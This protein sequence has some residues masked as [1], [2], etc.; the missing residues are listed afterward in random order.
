MARAILHFMWGF[1]SHFRSSVQTQTRSALQAIGAGLG[2]TVTLVGF[3]ASDA[4]PFD[5]CVEPENQPIGGLDLAGIDA[6]AQQLYEADE[7][8]GA[9]YSNQALNEA[10][11]RALRARARGQ[12]LVEVMENFA[13]VPGR[14]YFTSSSARVGDYMVYTVVGVLASRWA[15][16]PTLT[17]RRRDR[18]T[19]QP[20]LADAVVQHVLRAATRALDRQQ[21]PDGISDETPGDSADLV[22]AA[23]NEFV[24]SIAVLAGDYFDTGLAQDLNAVAAQPYEGRTSVGSIVLAAR[25][26]DAAAASVS[27]DA[28]FRVAVPTRNPRAF[29]KVLEMS[30]PDVHLL[31]TGSE[32]YGLGRA[33]DNYDPS[34]ERVFTVSI[35]GRGTWELHHAG[36]PLLRIENTH[37][38][39]PRAPMSR[40]QFDDTVERLFPETGTEDI[41]RLWELAQL[42]A[43]QEHGTMLVVHRAAADEADRLA[44]QA[45]RIEPTLLRGDVLR[46]T[47]NIDGAVLVAPDGR[48][49]AV[50]V[51]LDGTATGDGDSARGARYNSAVRYLQAA[52][53][54]CLIIIVSE[55]GMINLLPNLRRRVRP[56]TV[57]SAVK[58]MEDA[59][60]GSPIDYETFFRRREHVETL[61]FYLDEDQC[62][63]LNESQERVEDARWQESAMRVGHSIFAPDPDMNDSYFL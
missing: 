39:L 27:I 55:D 43:A 3:R 16:L 20:S 45:L 8:Y 10:R 30:G 18:M 4:A 46:S 2:P 28:G 61:A 57:E 35:V 33:A 59:S 48:C 49:H 12:A 1:Q 32:V 29:R 34:T 54:Q 21:P 44:P 62:A 26:T 51:I 58:A 60:Y 31:C 37:P 7:G 50:G 13:D 42:A 56:A 38:S 23:A 53:D 41:G 25:P 5:W 24:T 22:R 40:D 9:F 17:T 63:R 11:H 47:T 19:I 36:T 6:R 14:K 52:R 15:Q